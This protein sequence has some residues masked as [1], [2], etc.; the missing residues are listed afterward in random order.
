[1]LDS[2]VEDG[3]GACGIRNIFAFVDSTS[4]SRDYVRGRYLHESHYRIHLDFH[5]NMENYYEAK[6]EAL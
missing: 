6:K 2:M 1:M 4:C 5:E 3:C